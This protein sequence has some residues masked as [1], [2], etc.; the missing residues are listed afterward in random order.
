MS[1]HLLILHSSKASKCATLEL[2]DAC[3]SQIAPRDILANTLRF[4]WTKILHVLT[5]AT[6]SYLI[7]HRMKH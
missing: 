6:T 4:Y 2:S 3:L 7:K 1:I 5:I